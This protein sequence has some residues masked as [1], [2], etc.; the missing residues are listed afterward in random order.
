MVRFRWQR[1]KK[2]RSSGTIPFQPGLLLVRREAR[3]VI[4]RL[5]VEAEE[6]VPSFVGE[7]R[8]GGERSP[9]GLLVP[10][11]L[12]SLVLDYQAIHAEGLPVEKD[13]LTETERVV[14]IPIECL[15]ELLDVDAELHQERLGHGAV[16]RRAIDG[17]GP[18]ITDQQPIR[19]A[20]FVAFGVAPEIVVIIQHQ[21][22][23]V[24]P[25]R[26]AEEVSR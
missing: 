9:T 24:R 15:V 16:M 23:G 17:L 5:L 7:G 1:S 12:A 19:V 6:I 26:L 3:Q 21:D 4:H 25:R 20:E 18:P 2:Q 14:E 13:A 8:L 10:V 22:A 11:P